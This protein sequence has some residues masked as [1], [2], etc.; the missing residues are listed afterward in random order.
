MF[1]TTAVSSPIPIDYAHALTIVDGDQDLL[2]EIIYIFLADYP[3]QMNALRQAAAAQ[4]AHNVRRAAHR[5]KG[6]LGHI[7]SHHAYQLAYKIELMGANDNLAA[8]APEIA[9]LSSEIEDVVNFLSQSDW[10]AQASTAT[11]VP[12]E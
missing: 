6:G 11:G 5:L 3:Q 8:V 9:A 4:N 1:T 10:L 2:Q 12:H 7:G